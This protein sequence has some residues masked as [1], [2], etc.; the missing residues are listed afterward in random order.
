MSEIVVARIPLRAMTARAATSIAAC[1]CL[2]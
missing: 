2:P 1:V